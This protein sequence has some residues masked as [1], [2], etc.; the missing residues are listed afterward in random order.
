MNFFLLIP[1]FIILICFIPI[2]LEG[3]IS[4]N[5]L[6]MSGAVG[7]F[8]YK[9]KLT[10]QQ[11]WFENKKIYTRK[12]DSIESKELEFSSQEMIFVEMLFKE[13]RDKTRLKEISVFYN[14]GLGDA[15]SSAMVG[16]Y[17]NV[18]LFSLMG[19]IKNEKPTASLGIYDTISY[20]REVCQFAVKAIMSISLFDIV[21]SLL[22]SVILTKRN[23]NKS[24][25]TKKEKEQI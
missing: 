15:M 21:Y 12:Y 11:I 19:M 17:V 2:K 9:I 4:F 22:R 25:K 16:G 13:I 3:R 18:F 7:V 20:N 10:H 23:L 24:N 5:V 14:L 1:F 6:E 8:L